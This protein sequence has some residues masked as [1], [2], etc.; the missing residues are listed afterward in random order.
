MCFF[1]WN[2]HE[3]II[4][5]NKKIVLKTFTIS[6]LTIAF[7]MGKIVLITMRYFSTT[8][9]A[10]S[11]SLILTANFLIFSQKLN[12]FIAFE[13]T[14]EWIDKQPKSSDSKHIE[15]SRHELERNLSNSLPLPSTLP[16]FLDHAIFATKRAADDPKTCSISAR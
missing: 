10:F 9:I 15:K 16:A 11:C 5:C 1:C 14:F 12:K 4:V 6:Y 3:F 2:G 13:V 8:L 7:V